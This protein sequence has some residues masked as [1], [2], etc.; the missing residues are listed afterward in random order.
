MKWAHDAKSTAVRADA[1]RTTERRAAALFG[2]HFDPTDPSVSD[3]PVWVV[4]VRG[5]QPFSCECAV[6]ASADGKVDPRYMSMIVHLPTYS[7]VDGAFLT[8]DPLP[9]G[10]LGSVEKVGP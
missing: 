10:R 4:Q 1:V 2:A 7:S 9:L 5:G 6:R 3:D 8:T